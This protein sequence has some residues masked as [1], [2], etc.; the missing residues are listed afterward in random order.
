MVQVIKVDHQNCYLHLRRP[1]FFEE[2]GDSLLMHLM[3]DVVDI[4]VLF[5]LN[6]VS[7]EG[8]SILPKMRRVPTKYL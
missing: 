8:I 2:K 4:N 5:H 1:R 6:H 7:F 3:R